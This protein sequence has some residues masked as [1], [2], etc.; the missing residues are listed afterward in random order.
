[1]QKQV[2][3]LVDMQEEQLLQLLD[4]HSCTHKYFPRRHWLSFALHALLFPSLHLHTVKWE[5]L[6][7]TRQEGKSSSPKPTIQE[8]SAIGKKVSKWIAWKLSQGFHILVYANSFHV[9]QVKRELAYWSRYEETWEQIEHSVAETCQYWGHLISWG[10][11]N[12]QHTEVIEVEQ[13]RKRSIEIPKYF[14]EWP[15]E[16]YGWIRNCWKQSCLCQ[17]IWNFYDHLQHMEEFC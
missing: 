15:L 13:C 1:M 6:L 9:E 16:I 2:Q 12:K 11:R 7:R 14:V 4:H 5:H 3:K 10:Q 8:F 17:Y